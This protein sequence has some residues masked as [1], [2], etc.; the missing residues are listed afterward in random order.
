LASSQLYAKEYCFTEEQ[1]GQIVVDLERRQYCEKQIE[2]YIELDNEKTEQIE[3]LDKQV[4]GTEEKFVEAERK[5]A[6]DRKIADERDSARLK[7]LEEARKP[8][9][10]SIFG[11][12]G[13][14]V[15]S[16][17]LLILLL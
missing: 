12:F 13:F 3:L 2:T 10:N 6:T 8:R 9:W 1:T 16:G 11:S 14:G 4:R 7:E 17:L 5:N 15:I